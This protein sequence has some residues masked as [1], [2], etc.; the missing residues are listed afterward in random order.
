M[1]AEPFATLTCFLNGRTNVFYPSHEDW[2]L[3]KNNNVY[4]H[5]ETSIMQ[6]CFLK[7]IR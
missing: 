1:I 6:R 3:S 5:L 7:I 4:V 2:Q